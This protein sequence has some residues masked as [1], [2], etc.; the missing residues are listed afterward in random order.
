[1][2]VCSGLEKPFHLSVR[3]KSTYTTQKIYTFL[4][5]IKTNLAMYS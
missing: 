1:M 2:F 5:K 4:L 3:Q